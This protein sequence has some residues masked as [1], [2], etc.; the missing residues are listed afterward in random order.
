LIDGC[1]AL[2][3]KE[4]LPARFDDWLTAITDDG[5]DAA[6]PDRALSVSADN[7]QETMSYIA[8]LLRVVYI[9]P[10]EFAQRKARNASLSAPAN[11]P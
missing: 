1:K 4:R 9:E 11:K 8:E 6:H 10:H 3:A 5:H 7:I 2:I